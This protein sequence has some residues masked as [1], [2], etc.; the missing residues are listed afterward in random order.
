MIEFTTTATERPEIIR[1]CYGTFVDCFEGPD[2][3]EDAKLYINIDP[4]PYDSEAKRERV[5][6]VA[7]AYFAEVEHRIGPE[8]GSFPGAINWLFLQPFGEF[9]FHL[10]DDWRFEGT[11][12]FAEYVE[13]LR[14]LDNGV[15]CVT[16]NNGGGNRF[17]M[18]PSLMATDKLQSMI[19]NE[20]VPR[21]ENPEQYIIQNLERHIGDYNVTCHDDV[22]RHDL[23]R[24][25]ADEVGVE[26]DLDWGGPG[27]F[28]SW[29]VDNV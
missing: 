22:M 20:P 9:F 28:T 25:W 2:L 11:I 13:A 1:E 17:H 6:D 7:N 23:G 29:E 16:K 26:K 3:L 19:L 24:S 15:Q 4:V 12:P 14:G 10:E 21:D 27:N 18:P 8:G 5:L